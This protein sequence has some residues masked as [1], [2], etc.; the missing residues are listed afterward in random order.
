MARPKGIPS[1]N[2]TYSTKTKV[3]R[4]PENLD[5]IELVNLR[6]SVL[7]IVSS[8]QSEIDNNIL[9]YGSLSPR[10]DRAAVLISELK[11]CLGS[12]EPLEIEELPILTA[13]NS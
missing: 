8:W 11:D 4:I 2:R 13:I 7:A 12:P 9:T 5:A 6:E 10:Y 1:T 3:V